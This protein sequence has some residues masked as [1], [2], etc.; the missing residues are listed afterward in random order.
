MT[1]SQTNTDR[2]FLDRSQDVLFRRHTGPITATAP[3]RTTFAAD[4]DREASRDATATDAPRQVGA[5]EAAVAIRGEAS[6]VQRSTR[7][8]RRA[9]RRSNR[10]A[11]AH[12][13]R[14]RYEERVRQVLTRERT[15]ERVVVVQEHDRRSAATGYLTAW[16]PGIAVVVL[17]AAMAVNDPGFVYTTL[18]QVFDVP[19][20]VHFL[21]VTEGDVVVALA[22]AL[23]TTATLLAAAHLVG[24]ALGT[25]LFSGPLRND[26]HPEVTRTWDD[27][28]P[29]RMI[30]SALIGMAVLAWFIRFLHTIAAARFEQD[31]TAVFGGADK[32][33]ASVVWFITLLPVV[34]TAFEIVSSAPQFAHARKASRWSLQMRLAERRH[35]RRDQRL[36]NRERAAHRRALLAI[37]VLTDILKDVSRRSLAEIVEA[38]LATGRV[39]LTNVNDVLRQA[40]SSDLE[41]GSGQLPLDLSG[42]TAHAYLPGLP[43]VSNTVA[44]AINAFT[45]L[46]EVPQHAPLAADWRDLRS[47]PHAYQPHGVRT[48]IDDGLDHITASAPSTDHEFHDHDPHRAT[49]AVE[50]TTA[51][52][53]SAA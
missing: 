1:N 36:L 41:A 2:S 35:V 15:R 5:P 34:V 16:L 20:S 28:R 31:V 37:L 13:R 10:A 52:T 8:A 44:H 3:A 26:E 25:V 6:A 38:A 50:N 23:A 27:L 9:E 40:P 29:G 32:I 14:A 17:A 45:D 47:D 11:R 21:D 24:K 51:A 39:D 46:A 48:A 7:P 19:T 33:S 49:R 42:T 30:L 12:R 18:R 22:A 53:E 4:I 43:V